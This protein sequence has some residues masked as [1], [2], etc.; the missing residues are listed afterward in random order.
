MDQESEEVDE[1]AGGVGNN[2][3][4][5]A[6][7]GEEDPRSQVFVDGHTP[8]QLGCGSPSWWREE[9][10]KREGRKEIC[11]DEKDKEKKKESVSV[12]VVLE[13]RMSSH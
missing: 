2:L 5:E 12:K 7:L 6:G 8:G 11:G 3:D 10:R 9:G 1:I 4:L 13:W